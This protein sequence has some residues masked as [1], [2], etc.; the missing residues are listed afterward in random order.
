MKLSPREATRY[1]ANPD[2]DKAGLLIY[3]ADAMRVA[4]RRQEVIRTLLGPEGEEEMRLTRISAPDLRKEKSLLHDAIKAQ[5]FFPGPRVAFVEDAGDGLAD[6]FAE[7]LSDWRPGDAQIIVTSGQLNARSKIRK[8]F[9]GEGHVFAVGIYDDPPG[10]EE[11]E[12]ILADGGLRNVPRD[13][14]TDIE[15]LAR[16]LDPGDFRQTMEKLS[17]YKRH[18]DTPVSVMDLEAIAPVSTDAALDDILNVVAEARTPEI[19]PLM[20]KLEGQGI[21]PTTLCIG[22]LRHFRILHAAAADPGGPASG[23]SKSRPPV[24]GPRRDRMIRQAQ[25]WGMHK[26]EQALGVLLE[27]DLALRTA[28]Q[29]APQMATVER[30]M[31]RLAMLGRR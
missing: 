14:M 2:P 28:G 31:I 17:L 24:F 18:D 9:E 13:A 29:T 21:N 30:T 3:G 23:I 7:V 26:L 19:G 12:A 16:T 15:A 6:I 25:G 5:G 8:L 10:R 11:I 1:F 20:S 22:A 27:T 4:L